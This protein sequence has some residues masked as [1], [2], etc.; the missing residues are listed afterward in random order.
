MR[1]TFQ[2]IFIVRAVSSFAVLP[3]TSRSFFQMNVSSL[4]LEILFSSSLFTKNLFFFFSGNNVHL[5]CKKT[6]YYL[7]LIAY[8]LNVEVG[9]ASF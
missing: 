8:V 4:T 6:L 9:G 3:S 7:K 5:F 1:E 2:I